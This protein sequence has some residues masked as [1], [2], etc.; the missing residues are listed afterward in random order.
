ME[1]PSDRSDKTITGE[2]ILIGILKHVLCKYQ[3]ETNFGVLSMFTHGRDG[4]NRI[5][6]INALLEYLDGS[7]YSESVGSKGELPYLIMIWG[8]VHCK[9]LS[10]SEYMQKEIIRLAQNDSY[11]EDSQNIL[12]SYPLQPTNYRRK[13]IVQ[14]LL[15]KKIRYAALLLNIEDN[16]NVLTFIEYLNNS[17]SNIHNDLIDPFLPGVF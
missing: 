16:P 14:D 11:F 9:G 7:I 1:D 10:L 13:L 5:Q 17:S 8:I 12:D 15:K 4:L 2:T 3:N 6:K